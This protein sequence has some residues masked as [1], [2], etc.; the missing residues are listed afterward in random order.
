MLIVFL[1]KNYK[2]I[3][4]IVVNVIF[5]RKLDLKKKYNTNSQTSIISKKLQ[6]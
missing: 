1:Y 4:E 5:I 2:N 3:V 6:K